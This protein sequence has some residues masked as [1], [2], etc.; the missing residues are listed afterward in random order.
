M[1][2]FF[3]YLHQRFNLW[4]FST[5]TCYL[6][7]FSKSNF[8]FD[9]NDIHHFFLL[10]FFLLV[11][12]LYDDLKN[13]NNDKE[14]PDRIYTNITRAKE[15][16][17]RL[18]VLVTLLLA[19]LAYYNF[20]LALY[21]LVFFLFNHLLYYLLFNKHTFKH[22]LPLLK[23]PLIFI[24]LS[25][26]VN[27]TAVALFLAF[28]VFEIIEDKEFPITKSYAWLL[29]TVASLLL[30]L[31][32]PINHVWSY[33]LLFILIIIVLVTHSK[34]S[35]YFYLALFLLSRIIIQVDEI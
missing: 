29:A 35:P 20:L 19:W 5:L 26:H 21:T 23:Y 8:H 11:M 6:L 28:L 34:Y 33:A 13:T 18:Y 32:K 10:L 7:I 14:K 1:N 24:A 9:F 22:Y 17:I 27:I 3:T 12:R 16:S 2:I 15:L 31:E 4:L 30:F 25:N